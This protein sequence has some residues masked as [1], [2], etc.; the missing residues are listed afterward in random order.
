MSV[1]RSSEQRR[2]S[3]SPAGFACLIGF[4]AFVWS[5]FIPAAYVA[6]HRR[7]VV[8]PPDEVLVEYVRRNWTEEAGFTKAVGIGLALGIATA[9]A[10]YA[11]RASRHP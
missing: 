6:L 5:L 4:V 8:A 10:G 9:A 11:A 1:A 2:R 7:D 3:R